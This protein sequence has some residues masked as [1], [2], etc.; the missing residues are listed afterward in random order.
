M[1]LSDV[2]LATRASCV[3]FRNASSLLLADLPSTEPLAIA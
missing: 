3:F 1:A 2:F